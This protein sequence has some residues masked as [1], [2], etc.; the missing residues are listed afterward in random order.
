MGRGEVRAG[1]AYVEL[2]VRDNKF[3]KGLDAAGKRLRSFGTSAMMSGARLLGAGG[4][5]V[6]PLIAMSQQFASVGDQVN[7]MAARTGIATDVL[8]ELGFAAEQSGSDLATVEKGVAR[9]QRSLLDAARG[10]KTAV[11]AL[12]DL[13]LSAESLEGLSPEQ[14]FKTIGAAIA[15]VEDPSRR[16]ALAMQLFGKSGQKL[17]PLLLSDIEALQQEARDLGLSISPEEAQSAADLTDAWN[18]MKR[19]MK[20]VGVVIGGAVA[21]SFTV[22][23]NAMAQSIRTVIGFIKKNQEV[24]VTILKV[25][26]AV[27][28]A[29]AAFIAIGGILFAAGVAVTGFVAAL[30]FVGTIISMILSPLGTRD[31]GHRG[32]GRGN[33]EIHRSWRPKLSSGY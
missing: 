8:S 9:M 29:G 26:L 2:L 6:A 16:A 32:V 14:Q 28:A 31:R 20:A 25:G 7:K 33:R 22:A 30:G 15:K 12:A 27:A 21:K 24:V 19:T 23:A 3:I 18:R 17:L 5:V 11:D 13:G 4:A 1:R 10:S